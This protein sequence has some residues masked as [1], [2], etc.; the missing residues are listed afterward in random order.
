MR[1]L[2]AV[3][4]ELFTK[5]LNGPDDHPEDLYEV[6]E[7][8]E[9]LEKRYDTDAHLVTYVVEGATRQFRINKPGLPY[10]DKPLWTQVL[11]CDVDNPGHADWTEDMVEAAY[12][13]YATLD[14]LR[15][16]GIY[17]TKRGLRFVQPLA[18]SIP[19]P[20]V[21][22][23]IAGWYHQLEEAGIKVDRSC[24]DWTHHFRLPHVYRNHEMWPSP[25]VLLDRMRPIEPPLP[26]ELP[27]MTRSERARGPRVSRPVR[28]AAPGEVPEAWRPRIQPIADAVR[29]VQGNWHE[30]FLALSGA[31]LDR[32]APAE[33]LPAIVGA[34]SIATSADSRT[35]D[36]EG[37]ARTTLDRFAAGYVYRGYGTLLCH[38]PDVA[39]AIDRAVFET[40][41]ARPLGE[42]TTELEEVIRKAPDGLTVISAECGL[43]KTKA[44]IK[45]A[46]ERASKEYAS[47]NALG[48]RAPLGSKT[49]ISVD[50]HA[51]AQQ[52]V[53]DL[54]VPA[55][56]LFG[57]LSCKREDGQRECRYYDNARP[58]VQ[59]GMPMRRDVCENGKGNRCE[60]FE[61][62][63]ARDGVEGPQD[64]RV[65]VGPHQLLSSLDG[66]AGSTGLLIIDE[67]P[68]LLESQEFTIEDIGMAI[69]ISFHANYLD[70]AFTA[71]IIPAMEA[72]LGFLKDSDV[73]DSADIDAAIRKFEKAATDSNLK[74]ARASS[75]SDGDPVEC[76][77]AAPIEKHRGHAPPLTS[78]GRHIALRDKERAATIGK[79][80]RVL[81]MVHHGVT[82]ELPVKVRV[83]K[84]NEGRVLVVT[85]CNEQLSQAIRRK[86]AV[87]VMDANAEVNLPIYTKL[88]GYKPF[89]HKFSAGDG[90]PI[91]RTLIGCASASR[92]GWLHRGGKPNV[93][94][95]LVRAVQML[96]EWAQEDRE[97]RSLAIITMIPIEETLKAASGQE[98]DKRWGP[99]DEAIAKLGPI[100]KQWPGTILFGH[101]GGVRGLNDMA[102]VDCLATLGDPWPN[103]GAVQNQVAFLALEETW[104]HRMGALC[105]ADLEQA[106][107]RLRPV[108]RA[109]LG[110]ALH[111]G[112]VLPSGTGWTMG[113][114]E[115][116]EMDS[117]PAKNASD[118]GVQELRRIVEQLGG[119]RVAARALGCNHSTIG[120]YL[121][122]SRTVSYDIASRLRQKSGGAPP[123]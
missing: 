41:S 20:E 10:F 81:R 26:M 84:Q 89:F 61:N 100:I 33:H 69:T 62:C 43:G 38:H 94:S 35:A 73:G 96:F 34:I 13:Q 7:L 70:G 42:V 24:R 110:R 22:P 19:S 116:R 107:G 114:V 91:K 30:L 3:A 18:R 16:V 15:T 92:T 48:K 60:F 37:C 57:P 51:L 32:G 67:P 103:I 82:S 27:A 11:F 115:M 50:K 68:P 105:R 108:H 65:A 80:S 47:A 83:E 46:V 76:A 40:P 44:A 4:P 21:E 87:V 12:E 112:R 95:S 5:G 54:S 71:A 117:A 72:L 74:Q 122:G 77:R 31:L 49:S 2:V 64:A 6:M 29:Q 55:K 119:V 78:F 8:R 1:I 45:I 63:K 53:G 75:G 39:R 52:I 79:A 101:Y 106:Q 93:D 111:I 113:E 14:V 66:E 9:A 59:G 58:L 88:L 25:V 118:M 56:R 17:H 120:A 23:Y 102:N 123:C 36:R 85:S 90:A 28:L 98:A 99:Y 86:G 121:N 109:R 97:A 104:E